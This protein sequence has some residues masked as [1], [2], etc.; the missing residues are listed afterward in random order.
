MTKAFRHRATLDLAEHSDAAMVVVSEEKGEIAF[1]ADKEIYR[2]LTVEELET[3]LVGYLTTAE[4][5]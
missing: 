2:N 3:W 5:K 4:V 1:A